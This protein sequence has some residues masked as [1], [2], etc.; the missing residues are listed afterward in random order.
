MSNDERPSKVDGIKQP[1]H[2]CGGSDFHIGGIYGPNASV[3]K[4]DDESLLVLMLKFGGESI[5][6]RA[7]RTCG[8][9]QMFL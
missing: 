1:C 8:N 6:A 2:I 5:R 7:C 9:V 4:A 3:F